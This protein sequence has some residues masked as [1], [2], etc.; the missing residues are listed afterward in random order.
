MVA[1]RAATPATTQMASPFFVTC[2]DTS[3]AL[4]AMNTQNWNDFH[5]AQTVSKR[6]GNRKSNRMETAT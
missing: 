2:V 4:V 3:H 1:T 6:D 5:T